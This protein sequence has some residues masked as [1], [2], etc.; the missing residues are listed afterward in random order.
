ML[1]IRETVHV[2]GQ[3]Y[4]KNIYTIPSVQFCCGT[5]NALKKQSLFKKKKTIGCGNEE[6]VGDL[7]R[8]VSM[9]C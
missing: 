3:G 7:K 4:L 6:V 2:W 8:A 9:R 1:I 5:K